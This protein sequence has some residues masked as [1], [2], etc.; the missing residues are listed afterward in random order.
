MSTKEMMEP[1]RVGGSDYVE[2]GAGVTD[3][4]LT[5]AGDGTGTGA[6]GDFLARVV[7][8]V[9]TAGAT[10]TVSITDGADSVPLVP[11]STPVGVYS[12]ELGIR[13]RT[14]P[15]KLTTGAAATALAIGQ[16]SA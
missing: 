6:K 13:A 16:F 3:R 5:N 8:Q 1:V 4:L 7:A 12:I 10:G 14:G 2:V 9:T 11:A 15:W